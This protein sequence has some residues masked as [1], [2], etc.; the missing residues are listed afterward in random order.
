MDSFTERSFKMICDERSI[1][2]FVVHKPKGVQRIE[3]FCYNKTFIFIYES[4]Q[5]EVFSFSDRK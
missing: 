1:S 2:G 5:K 3:K 4:L